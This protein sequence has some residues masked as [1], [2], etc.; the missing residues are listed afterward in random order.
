MRKNKNKSFVKDINLLHCLSLSFIIYLLNYSN[1]NAIEWTICR[2]LGV[3]HTFCIQIDF[4]CHRSNIFIRNKS[5]DIIFNFLLQKQSK[6]MS[7]H[8]GAILFAHYI[9]PLCKTTSVLLCT[10]IGIGKKC[11][12][13]G[14]IIF[15][16]STVNFILVIII[17]F[18]VWFPFEDSDHTFQLIKSMKFIA[19]NQNNN[20]YNSRLEEKIRNGNSERDHR[21]GPINQFQNSSINPFSI[22]FSL[23]N[24]DT[25][26]YY[27]IIDNR[28]KKLC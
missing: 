27:S 9:C 24:Y 6:I 3:D 18:L 19:G 4:R 14:A 10:Q 25:S 26:K 8:L 16:H 28:N 7:E 11:K 22:K 20:Q 23:S 17:I 12:K 2:I 5:R 13:C 15:P 1:N 21:A